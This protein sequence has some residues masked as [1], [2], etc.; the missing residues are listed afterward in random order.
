M[1]L[2]GCNSLSWSFDFSS[3]SM[4]FLLSILF[5]KVWSSITPFELKAPQTFSFLK[6]FVLAL[7]YAS[8]GETHLCLP[9]DMKYTD[10]SSVKTTFSNSLYKIQVCF[11]D[12]LHCFGKQLG[13]PSIWSLFQLKIL[14][15]LI[16]QPS[17]QICSEVYK[18]SFWKCWKVK[19][20][21][22][23]EKQMMFII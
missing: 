18:L 10:A 7:S 13:V 5:S 11:S 22:D 15:L 23:W 1:Y 19:N 16:C 8:P 9:R 3:I 12:L 2:F 14:K 4:Y 20:E 17:S 21:T 6:Y